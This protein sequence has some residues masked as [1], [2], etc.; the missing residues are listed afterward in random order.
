MCTSK[1]CH[2]FVVKTLAKQSI[3]LILERWGE[4]TCKTA[5][6]PFKFTGKLK[7]TLWNDTYLYYMVVLVT[8]DLKIK[9]K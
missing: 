3:A 9:K 1:E 2:I 7:L 4:I 5:W 8:T 6:E